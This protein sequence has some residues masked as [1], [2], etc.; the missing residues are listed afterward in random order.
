M[1]EVDRSARDQLVPRFIGFPD[2]R[3]VFYLVRRETGR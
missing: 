3:D 2:N 1:T